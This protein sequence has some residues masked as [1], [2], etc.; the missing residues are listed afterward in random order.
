MLNNIDSQLNENSSNSESNDEEQTNLNLQDECK[1]FIDKIFSKYHRDSRIKYKIRN[2]II[3]TLPNNI[4]MFIINNE[5]K[6]N[7]KKR[8][9]NNINEFIGKFLTKNKYFYNSSSDIYFY[10]DNKNYNTI[11]ED[12]IISNISNYINIIYKQNNELITKYNSKIQSDLNETNNL[13]ESNNL[14]KINSINEINNINE[15]YHMREKI[16]SIVFKKIKETN[17]NTYIPESQT[18]QKIFSILVPIF[19]TEKSMAKYFLVCIG[20]II[21]KKNNSVF[22]V[23]S[24]CKNLIKLLSS[25]CY[26]FFGTSYFT[27]FKYK[28]HEVQK[29]C[30]LIK[31]NT[32]NNYN[33]G[34][35]FHKN[36][37]N[38]LCV[39]M[40]Y[41]SRFN[42]SENFL[43]TEAD[44]NLTNYVNMLS[45][46]KIIDNFINNSIEYT[47]QTTNIITSKNMHYLWKEFL[48]TYNIPKIQFSNNLKIILSTKIKYDESKDVYYQVISKNLPNVSNFL[49]F[50][51]TNF[52]IIEN[53]NINK[54]YEISEILNI[55]KK[56][57]TSKCNL[58]EE[59]II[60]IINHYYENINII[61]KNVLN[62]DCNIWNKENDINEFL[63]FI[64][65]K[66]LL[67][68]EEYPQSLVSIYC[69]YVSYA[70]QFK[71]IISKDY[72]INFIKDNYNE[73]I[74]DEI[75]LTSWW[76]N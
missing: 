54:Y 32:Y 61:N 26:N 49:K 18:I 24:E 27:E 10:Y 38:L 31:I 4:N 37:L 63:I 44:T 29:N 55:Y 33:F 21:L 6:S 75:L 50:W 62:I 71:C 22:I 66:L 7:E 70:K 72:F 1:E 53:N 68:N 46:N 11:K 57:L 76:I 65:S 12:T 47:E 43:N 19:F 16:K 14:N 58:S 35:D 34:E 39:S 25:Y 67:N 13:N 20:D 56:Y 15:I 17:I 60:L 45:N 48:N 74:E 42:N 23:N 36:I 5:K 69:G 3:N 41:S 73:Y 40:H 28:Y 8:K 9:Q 51:D 59:N 52:K 30:K 2:Y 64:K